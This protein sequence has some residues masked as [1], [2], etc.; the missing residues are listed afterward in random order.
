MVF[1]TNPLTREE[2]ILILTKQSLVFNDDVKVGYNLKPSEA[3][4]ITRHVT[5]NVCFSVTEKR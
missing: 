4:N 5:I 1:F 2:K 3:P